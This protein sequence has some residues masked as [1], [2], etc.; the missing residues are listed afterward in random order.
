MRLGESFDFFFEFI[1]AR[2]CCGF[3]LF[4][5]FLHVKFLIRPVL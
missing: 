3:I 2:M 1:I 4:I 5:F